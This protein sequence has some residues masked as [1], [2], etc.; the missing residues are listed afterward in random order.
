MT[1]VLVVQS[2]ALNE[3]SNTRLLTG[4]LLT[5]LGRDAEVAVTTRDLAHHPLP[6]ITDQT[7]G[8]FFTP[9]DQRSAE[10]NEIIAL[11][12]TLVAEL[13]NTDII[14]I[15]APMYNFGVPSTLKA[16]FDHIARAGVTFKYTE[17]GPVGL[18]QGKQAYIVTATGGIHAGT[19]RDFVAP[20]VTTFLGFLGINAVETFA[21]EGMSMADMKEASLNQA[22]SAIE[23]L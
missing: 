17:T 13:M 12:D 15:A 11:S 14:I 4:K 19:P 5:R 3:T 23:Q 10:Q 9:A 6:H 22:I 8:A 7:L 2:S 20:Y 18:V 1:K 21:A 16:Y